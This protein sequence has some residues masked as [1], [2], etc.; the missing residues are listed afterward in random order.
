MQKFKINFFRYSLDSILVNWPAKISIEISTQI[1]SFSNAILKNPNILELRKGYCSLLIIFK[2]EID[3]Y[4][5]ICN[6]LLEIH[7]KLKSIH[8]AKNQFG[9]FQFVMKRVFI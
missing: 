2:T 4:E 1:N 8:P 5:E 7:K 6:S 9:K 3:N